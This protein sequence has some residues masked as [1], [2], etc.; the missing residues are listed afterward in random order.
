MN[1]ELLKYLCC[2]YCKDSLKTEARKI[3]IGNAYSDT[4]EDILDG[5]L[6]CLR[7]NN[8]YP[9]INGIPRLC[10]ELFEQEKKELNKLKN[11]TEVVIIRSKAIQNSDAY[12]QIEKIVRQRIKIPD[13]ASGYLRKRLE[14]DIYYRIKGCEK[15][16]KYIKTLKLF[17]N[18]KL[19]TILDIGG[20]Q[21]GLIKS[22]TDFFHPTLSILLD[23]DLTWVEVAMLRNP[24]VQIIRGD[25][26]NLPF[27]KG[28]IDLVISQ[29]MLEHIKEYTKAL[30]EMCEVAKETCFV[31]WGPNKFF[32]YDFGHLDAPVSIF[33]KKMAKYIAVLWH[34]I[35]K[36]RKSNAAIVDELENTHYISPLHVKKIFKNYGRPYNVFTNFALYSLENGYSE[37]T[38]GIKHYLLVM[39]P[40]AK[41]IFKLLVF[42]RIEPQCYFVLK[43]GNGQAK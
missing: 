8:E 36:T 42:F 5:I 12:S 38:K 24:T 40:V 13:D 11:I 39:R 21:G 10:K 25:A 20:G 28:S 33:P 3:Q 7:C 29:M 15:Q 32:I 31:C 23:Y 17:C 4:C 6:L 27:K 22:L 2:P 1:K 30:T 37:N 41:I 26:T 18:H 14:N 35:R 43:K 19:E 9:V 16:E 34:K